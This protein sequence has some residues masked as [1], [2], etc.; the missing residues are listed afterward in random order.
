MTLLAVA[1]RG[2]DVEVALFVHVL[3]AM[4]LVGTLFGAATALV[5]AWRRT[6]PG[7]VATLTRYGLW[8]IAAG[9]FPAWIVM[10]VGAQWVYSEE[11][12]D[13]APSEPG[14][15]GVGYITADAGGLLILISLILALVGL[16][17]M[18]GDN[19]SSTLGRVVAVISLV[20]LATYLVA[21][22]AM[23][24]KPD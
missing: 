12:W 18:R 16:R 11:H 3:G 2:S 14:W 10:R 13:D 9:A 4:L 6:E 23:S 1:D 17:R 7:S 15:L 22:W 5:L 19:P 21:V 8:T 24:A 20:V